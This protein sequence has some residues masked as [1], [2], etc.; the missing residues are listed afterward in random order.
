MYVGVCMYVLTH[1]CP[2]IHSSALS[3]HKGPAYSLE[4]ADTLL[5]SGGSADIKVWKWAELCNGSPEVRGPCEC[6]VEKIISHFSS[7]L[8]A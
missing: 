8:K 3:A 6:E 4:T 2:L 7:M 1:V 5:V